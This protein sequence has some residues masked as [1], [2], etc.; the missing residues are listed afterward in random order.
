LP[1]E[2]LTTL[3]G[4]RMWADAA[5]IRRLVAERGADLRTIVLD[6]T[7]AVLGVG[8][9][10]RVPPDWL[11]DAVLARHTTCSHPGCRTA[12]RISD[13]DHARPWSP[14]DGDHQGGATDAANLAPL[15]ARHNRSRE[16]EGWQ[17]Q[18]S[19]DGSRRWHHPRTGLSAQTL[20]GTSP[21]AIRQALLSSARATR[22][23]P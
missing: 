15:C 13:L 19:P 4:G 21:P 11:A 1:A 6:G 22:P 23:P 9:R 14:A 3:A 12:A 18:Q 17:A 8:R 7:G 5:T 2:L 10:T 16:R 20:T